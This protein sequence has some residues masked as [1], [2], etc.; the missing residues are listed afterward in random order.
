MF[1]ERIQEFI[2]FL[3]ASVITA[4]RL[5]YIERSHPCDQALNT[6][7]FCESLGELRSWIGQT[8]NLDPKKKVYG[9]I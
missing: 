9:N 4:T 1:D 2:D 8:V 6:L 5:K 7:N 3:K